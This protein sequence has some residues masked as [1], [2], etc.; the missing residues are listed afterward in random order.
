[1]ERGMAA[2]EGG[3]GVPAYRG[4]A[5][6]VAARILAGDIGPGGRVPSEREL[7]VEYGISRMTARSAIR[8]LEKRG[9]VERR[10]RSGTFVSAPKIEI[11]LSSVAGFS[12]RLLRQGISPGAEVVEARTVPAS[13]IDA[14]GAESLGVSADEAVHVLVRTRTGNGEPLALEESH[15]PARLCPD[16]LERDL[17]G[18]VYDVLRESYGL[19]PAHLRQEVEVTQL[20]TD[21][22]EKLGVRADVPIL[23]VVRVA[24]DAER[25]PI[26]FAR[27]LYRGDRLIFVSDT[28]QT[29][30]EG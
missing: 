20:D 22:A 25:R 30:E 26:E 10:G 6:E 21:A 15:F 8:L 13:E 27:D 4:A 12:S 9:L 29:S 11:D 1:M 19:D 2:T 16:L 18:S 17:T 5:R 23:R 3:G 24:W 14:R 7:A 28:E